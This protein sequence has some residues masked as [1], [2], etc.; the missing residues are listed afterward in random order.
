[1]TLKKSLPSFSP[2]TF[3]TMSLGRAVASF[4]K[5]IAV[6]RTAMDAG[7]WFHTSQEY[8]GGG[9][10]MVLRHAFDQ[11]RSKT[12]RLIFK[13]RCDRAETIRFD[14]EDACQRLNIEQVDVAQLCRDTHDH[15]KV[16]KDFLNQGPMWETCC[17][18]S[19]R[20]LVGNFVFEVFPGYAEDAL[21]AVENDLFDGC[22]LYLNPTQRNAT[23]PLWEAMQQRRTPLL[24]LRTLGGGAE[25][26]DAVAEV[27]R[28]SGCSSWPTFCVRYSLSVPGVLTTIGGTAS[29]S[30]LQELLSAAEGFEP[31]DAEVMTRVEELYRTSTI[32]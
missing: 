13:I 4:D 9:S 14:V 2:Y 25:A 21:E 29:E 24:A 8:S 28:G 27:F 6:A 17:D 22:I 3:G 15:R 20:G 7:V 18:L 11:D 31:L 12:P 10:F 26:S 16:V 5:D 30:H 19:D 32:T 23:P 1:M